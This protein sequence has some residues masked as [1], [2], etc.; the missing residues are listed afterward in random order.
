M[1]DRSKMYPTL[2]YR[3]LTWLAVAKE[4]SCLAHACDSHLPRGTDLWAPKQRLARWV[5]SHFGGATQML[6]GITGSV[7]TSTSGLAPCTTNIGSA[8][9]L[10][11][12]RNRPTRLN[13]VLLVSKLGTIA[14]KDIA[15]HAYPAS[16]R[17]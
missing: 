6:F 3:S 15:A 12:H 14:T 2:L 16:A 13:R 8:P 9:R 4:S 7:G 5:G 11:M 10:K 17:A 1:L